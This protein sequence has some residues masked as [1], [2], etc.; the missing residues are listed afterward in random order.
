MLTV[1]YVS[2]QADVQLGERVVTSGQD[3]IFPVGFLV[4]T[5]ERSEKGT[6][7]RLV[8]VRPAVDFSHVDL[9]LVVLTKPE[10]DVDPVSATGAG[11]PA[12]S[13]ARAAGRGRG[14]P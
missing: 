4:G 2:N 6:N 13:E 5:V 12:L 11:T 10:G 14:H 8:K 9:V 7:Y 1:D 3:A